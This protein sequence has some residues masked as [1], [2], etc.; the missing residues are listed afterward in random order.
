[1]S[2]KK[3]FGSVEDGRNYLSDTDQKEAFKDVESERNLEQLKE[4]KK[5]IG[6]EFL[7]KKI[8]EFEIL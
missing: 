5:I 3:L 6:K 2:I 8:M 4:I 7:V 1:M